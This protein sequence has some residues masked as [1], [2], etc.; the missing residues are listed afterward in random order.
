MH[1]HPSRIPVHA[2]DHA[3]YAGTALGLQAAA[4]DAGLPVLTGIVQRPGCM[5]C[6][7]TVAIARALRTSGDPVRDDMSGYPHLR[8]AA[9]GR[10]VVRI[11]RGAS[12][13]SL[14]ASAL[15]A[16]AERVLG[17]KLYDTTADG[18]VSLEP[19]YCLGHCARSPAISIDHVAHG[20]VS[21][22]RFEVL[23]KTLRAAR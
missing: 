16:H 18:A 20:G 4:P 6:P 2:G 14:G 1:T 7:L 17:A 22:E 9:P 13:R 15:L 12:C 5:P 10:H 8:C 3:T 11:C 19:V 21:P 23:M